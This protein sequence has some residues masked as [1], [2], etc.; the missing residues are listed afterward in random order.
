PLGLVTLERDLCNGCGY[1]VTACPFDVPRLESN[2]LTGWGKATK[3]NLCQDRVTEGLIPACVK[4]CPPGAI[5]FG[6]RQQMVTLGRTRAAALQEQGFAEASLYGPELL[7]GLGR[8]FVLAARP[9]KYGLPERP[10]Y[11]LAVT[12]W[13]R[14]FQPLGQLGVLATVFGLAANWVVTRRLRG[15][16]KEEV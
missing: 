15:K 13:Q 5:R 1:C 2:P 14:L 3:C 9:A 7:G 4:T 11:P 6:D 12:L 16:K 10:T 8:M